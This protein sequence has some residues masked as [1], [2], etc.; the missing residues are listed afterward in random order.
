MNML[1]TYTSLFEVYRLSNNAS[2]AIHL[3]GKRPY[4][5]NSWLLQ[6]KKRATW[7]S[8]LNILHFHYKLEQRI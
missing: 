7:L 8:N 5:K 3:T 4:N 1:S 6:K 2:G